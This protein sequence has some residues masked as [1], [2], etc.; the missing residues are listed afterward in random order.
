M[1]LV[2]GA[3]S[4]VY[5]YLKENIMSRDIDRII[6]DIIKHQELID[7]DNNILHKNMNNIYKDIANIKKELTGIDNKIDLILEILN[8]LTIMVLQEEEEEEYNNEWTP[9]QD[10]EWN[11]YEDD[12]LDG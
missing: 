9:E 4:G 2:G 8:N 1:D 3:I 6:G 12:Q 10:E 5:P 11:S 7:N